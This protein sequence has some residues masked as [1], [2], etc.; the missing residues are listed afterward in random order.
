MSIQDRLIAFSNA[1]R[2]PVFIGLLRGFIG[3]FRK[4]DKDAQAVDLKS[5]RDPDFL[6]QKYWKP[7]LFALMPLAFFLGVHYWATKA[8]AMAHG[9]WLGIWFGWLALGVVINSLSGF[10]AFKHD[11]AIKMIR[12]SYIMIALYFFGGLGWMTLT[13]DN[14]LH[15]FQKYEVTKSNVSADQQQVDD[16]QNYQPAV[17]YVKNFEPQSDQSVADQNW[18]LVVYADNKRYVKNV[19]VGQVIHILNENQVK[20]TVVVDNQGQA[21]FSAKRIK[22]KVEKDSHLRFILPVDGSIKYYIDSA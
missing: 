17:D 2:L 1:K 20:Y 7:A 8:I 14:P 6:K 5:L 10:C 21:S 16:S 15:I 3:S 12:F 4:A 22:V 9:H 18:T 11:K 19:Q 13:N